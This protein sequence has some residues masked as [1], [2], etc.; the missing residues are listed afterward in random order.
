MK[1]E[2][3]IANILMQMGASPA[4]LGYAY[5]KSAVVV[6]IEN[7]S[8]WRQVTKVLYPEVAKIHGTTPSRAERAIRHCIEKMYL[9]GNISALTKIIPSYNIE[10]GK[11]TNSE[12]LATLAEYLRQEGDNCGLAMHQDE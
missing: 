9:S 8:D 11:A 1:L 2:N 3:R 12:F 5:I 7:K 4:L 10:K 6:I